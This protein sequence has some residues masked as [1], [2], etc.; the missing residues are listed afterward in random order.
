M[1]M[2]PAVDKIALALAANAY[3]ATFKSTV[4]T[5]AATKAP[6]RTRR[7]LTIVPDRSAAEA[8]SERLRMLPPPDA[9]APLQALDR[10]LQG[11]ATDYGRATAD[12][13][14]LQM[15]YPTR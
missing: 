4:Y 13:V 8:A 3:S 2:A 7:G 6:L 10:A 1:T 9:Q 14:A 15:E 11:I 5:V 12:W